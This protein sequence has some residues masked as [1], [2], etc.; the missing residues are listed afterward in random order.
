MAKET[1]KKICSLLEDYRMADAIGLLNKKAKQ[2]SDRPAIDRLAQL[3]ETYR[4]M[5]HYLVEGVQDSGRDRLYSDLCGQLLSIAEGLE[6]QSA[7]AEGTSHYCA[8]IRLSKIRKSSVD[9]LLDDY[10][11][12]RAEMMLAEAAGSTD[13]SLLESRED[14]FENLFNAVYTLY[15]SKDTCAYL[16]DFMMSE[17]ADRNINSLIVSALTLGLLEF[18]DR[19]RL[20]LLLDIYDFSIDPF[21]SARALAGIVLA[22]AASP[23]AVGADPAIVARIS[24]WNDTEEMRRRLRETIRVIVGTRD[25][26]RLSTKMNEEVL[27]ELMKLRPDLLNNIK[28]MGGDFD[29]ASIEDNPEWQEILEKSGLEKKMREL[30]EM[31]SEGADLMMVTFSKLKEFPFFRLAYSWFVPFYVENPHAALP[32]EIRRLMTGIDGL[33]DMMC[34][35]DKYSLALSFRQMPDTQRQIISSQF[36]AQC[37]QLKAELEDKRLKS[38]APEFDTNVLLAVRDLYRFFKLYRQRRDFNDPFAKPFDFIN[39][40]GISDV[41]SSDNEMMRIVAEFYFTRGY[42]KEALPLLETLAGTE[43]DDFSIWEKIGYSLQQQGR[44]KEALEAY[45]KSELLKTPGT[46]LMRRLASLYRRTGNPEKAIPY[47]GRLLEKD[48]DNVSLI[49]NAGNASYEAGD[50]ES[51]LRHFY[52]ANY[53]APENIKVIRTLAWMQLLG[54][55]IDKS[56][57]SYARLIARPDATSSDRMNAGHAAMLSGDLKDA[58][59]HYLDAAHNSFEDFRMAY[60]ADLPT[61][62]NLGLDRHIFNIMLDNIKWKSDGTNSNR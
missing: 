60:L 45:E 31:Q 27:P 32:E 17:N 57:D 53:L 55:N 37:E 4:Y 52:H 61:L 25:T 41:L 12:L 54:G 51:A 9:R 19:H 8:T 59:H 14:I 15:D 38:S 2:L 56:R 18:Y 62:A 43:A 40:P 29:P 3:S 36:S 47:Y 46:W 26:E 49:M 33:A 28:K 44:L 16:R 24:L 50:M 48:P 11:A 7:I 13:N 5:M 6:R 35:S 39:L 20:N 58:E 22:I 1:Y 30:G 23:D 34:E 42:Y 21:I 10:S